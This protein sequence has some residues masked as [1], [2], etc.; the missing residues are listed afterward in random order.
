MVKR[1]WILAELAICM[2]G[3]ACGQVN[4]LTLPRD[5]DLKAA[6]AL[7][8]EAP[9]I[10][11]PNADRFASHVKQMIGR[12]APIDFDPSLRAK[13]LGGGIEPAFKYVRDEI[14]FETY[15]G[16]MREQNY[17]LVHSLFLPTPGRS[18]E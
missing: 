18:Q 16:V 3:F 2:C 10:E 9:A 6:M 14:R 15:P 17:F 11:L 7:K 8:L 4:P 13:A 1:S 12:F 5:A